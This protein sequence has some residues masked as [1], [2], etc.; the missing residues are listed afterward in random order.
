MVKIKPLNIIRRLMEFNKWPGRNE[1]MTPMCWK[2][3][4]I[5]KT[6]YFSYYR[7]CDERG[8]ERSFL[9]ERLEDDKGI[10]LFI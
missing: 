8:T 7:I 4:K 3:Y 6:D 5:K 1:S 2:I 10:A 9:E